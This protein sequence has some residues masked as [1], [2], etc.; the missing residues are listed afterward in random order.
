MFGFS[1]NR[2]GGHLARS[3]MLPEI[4]TVLAQLPID[5]AL[6]EIALAITADNVLAKPTNASREKSLR[7]LIQLY[8]LDPAF[9]L[10]RVL[11]RL[12]D[13]DPR[14]LPLMAMTCA[15]CRDEQLRASFELIDRLR[16]GQ[17]MPR[18]LMEQQLEDAFPGRF[19][20]AM[21]KS[22]A[23]N[24]NTTW[25]ESGHLSGR[26]KKI[27]AIPEPRT[28]ASTYA[29]FA[30]YLLGLRGDLLLGSVFGRLVASDPST[31]TAH[32]SSAAARG[33]LRFRHGGGV[34]EVDFSSL[35]TNDELRVVHG[36]H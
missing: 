5:A 9:A 17:L 30:G 10:F 33:L 28:L 8:G 16:P 1:T 20:P 22:L 26:S 29:M 19:S 23:Q 15:F 12:A 14:C 34:M 18:A 13:E 6:P 11:R 21:K 25:T 4:S 36:S 31:I 27:R 2:T 35:L 3:M 24:V 32:L 7:H